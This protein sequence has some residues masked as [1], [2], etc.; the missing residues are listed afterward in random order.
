MLIHRQWQSLPFTLHYSQGDLLSV[1]CG[2]YRRRWR[3]FS[4]RRCLRR[5]GKGGL[6]LGF[7]GE[8]TACP[9]WTTCLFNGLSRIPV[10]CRGCCSTRGAFCFSRQRFWSPNNPASQL[11]QSW[12]RLIDMFTI[13]WLKSRY[14]RR[15]IE[16]AVIPSSNILVSSSFQSLSD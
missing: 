3:R 15:S 10:A 12:D 9:V 13:N 14:Y 11:Y 5:W 7:S 1:P 16:N 8:A 6:L 4:S 2:K